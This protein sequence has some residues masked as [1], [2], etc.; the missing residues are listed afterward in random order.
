MTYDDELLADLL[1]ATAPGDPPPEALVAYARDAAALSA[2]ARARVEAYLAASP[3]HRDRFRVLAPRDWTLPGSC[4]CG[5]VGYVLR[6]PV[7]D[8]GNCHCTVCRKAYGAAFA[9]FAAVLPDAFRWVRGEDLL[10][11]FPTRSGERFFCSRCGTTLGG[12]A[13]PLFAVALATLDVDPVAR[14]RFHAH[15]AQKAPWLEIRDD[16]DRLEGGWDVPA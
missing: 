10:T 13:G 1:S 4:L 14:P 16:L 15:V 5:G 3:A 11:R 8:V 2:A 7:L 6:G 12:P 9:T